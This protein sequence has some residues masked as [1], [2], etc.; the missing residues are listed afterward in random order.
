VGLISTLVLYKKQ[1]KTEKII[2]YIDTS[3]ISIG[4]DTEE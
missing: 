3:E 2:R 4:K 1:R